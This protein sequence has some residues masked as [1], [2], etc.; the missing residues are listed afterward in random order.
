MRVIRQISQVMTRLKELK[1]E[2]LALG[3]SELFILREKVRAEQLA[4][5]NLFRQMAERTK[6]HI[7]KAERRLSNLRQVNQADDIDMGERH[8]LNVS[9]WR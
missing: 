2:R 4:G 7:K 5:R 9:A 3:L 8:G 1:T 6:T